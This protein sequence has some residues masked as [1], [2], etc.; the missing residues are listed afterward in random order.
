M[1]T[2]E[3]YAARPIAVFWSTS[4]FSGCFRFDT[5][6]EAFAY[7]DTQWTRIRDRVQ[8][9]R[10]CASDLRS[11]YLEAPELGR[12]SLRYVLLTADVSS[13]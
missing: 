9:E 4:Y 2:P 5:L 7:I 8:G 1:M 6:A 12:V 10:Y 13:Y 3:I 11:S